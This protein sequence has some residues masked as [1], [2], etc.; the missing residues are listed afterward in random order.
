MDHNKI[1]DKIISKAILE[2]REKNNQIY[3]ENHHI[4]PKSLGGSDDT[5]NLV[6]LTA[7][8]HFICH[9]LLWK[10]YS[11]VE[12]AKM[13]HALGLMRFHSSNKR[14][15]NSRSYEISRKAHAEATSFFHKNRKLSEAELH[16]RKFNNPNSKPVTI[17]GV[18]YK[19]KKD[20]IKNLKTTKRKL[21]DYL[22]GKISYE[23]MIS[24]ER[25]KHTEETKIRIGKYS[26]G[27]KQPKD[28]V[29]KR[30]KARLETLEKRKKSKIEH[31]YGK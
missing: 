23:K 9:W 4:L 31:Y 7:R 16:R 10:M 8:E 19:S 26:R 3:Y 6:L 22:N 25:P 13:G 30:I 12:K 21:Y 15:L 24:N 5:N 28:L 14:I 1:Y 11:G 20:A 27:K 18:T 29:E 17:N 2:N